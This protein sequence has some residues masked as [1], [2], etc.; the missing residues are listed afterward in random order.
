MRG[1]EER[2]DLHRRIA[3]VVVD[4][5]RRVL[6][7]ALATPDARR[8][9]RGPAGRGRRRRRGA[10]RDPTG[11]RPGRARAAADPAGVSDDERVLALGQH[12]HDAGEKQ[13][14]TDLLGERVRDAAA[15]AR[16]G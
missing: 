3:G 7:L 1:E 11:D 9:A 2:R 10:R 12:L 16:R 4:E 8:G 15:R 6:H 14:L 5:H 13:R